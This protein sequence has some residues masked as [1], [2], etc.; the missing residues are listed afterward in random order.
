MA[1]C[2]EVINEVK[3]LN[4]ER[5]EKISV[6]FVCRSYDLEN[7]NNIK[8]LF[9]TKNDD[10][11]EVDWVKVPVG[12]LEDES[13]KAVV[14]NK[15]DFLTK[16][17]K[18][19]LKTPSSLYIWTKLD[20]NMDYNEC[21]TANHLIETWWKQLKTKAVLDVLSEEVVDK[22]KNTLVIKLDKLGRLSISKRALGDVNE[23][24]C[25]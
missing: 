18:N 15:Y 12:E 4:L 17:L 25:D 6:I 14:G 1:V 24:C 16:K 22:V 3:R 8:S 11:E 5:K 9:E 20:N 19:V 7:D 2:T 13:V 23:Y 10:S 21:S